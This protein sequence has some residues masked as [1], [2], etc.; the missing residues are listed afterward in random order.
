[1]SIHFV[2]QIAPVAQIMKRTTHE[3]GAG[4]I[5]DMRVQT[6]ICIQTRLI[7]SHHMIRMMNSGLGPRG[8]KGI[9]RQREYF[10]CIRTSGID[11]VDGVKAFYVGWK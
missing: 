3:W 11:L 6:E 10:F 4:G 5:P 9:Q 7:L 1:M 8:S 2:T